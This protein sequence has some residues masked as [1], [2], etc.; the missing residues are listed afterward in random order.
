[1]PIKIELGDLTVNAS[2]GS[3]DKTLILSGGSARLLPLTAIAATSSVSYD[4][5][6]NA[7]TLPV[8]VVDGVPMIGQPQLVS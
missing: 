3:G 5:E 7:Y 6:G 1:M 8:V 4:S 2:Q